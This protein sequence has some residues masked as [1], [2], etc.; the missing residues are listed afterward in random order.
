MQSN[1]SIDPKADPLLSSASAVAPHH[2]NPPNAS[3]VVNQE[4]DLD[5]I[6]TLIGK[7]LPFEACLYHQILPLSIQGSKLRLGMVNLQDAAALD[8]VRRILAFLNYS[9]IPQTI[10]S[11]THHKVLSAYLNLVE[12]RAKKPAHLDPAS[13][14]RLDAGS[15]A[16][17]P[18]P[19]SANPAS[20]KETLVLES[21]D[22]LTDWNIPSLHRNTT[23]QEGK[24][25]LQEDLS[26]ASGATHT[27]IQPLSNPA[28]P[29]LDSNAARTNGSPVNPFSTIDPAALDALDSTAFPRPENGDVSA[30]QLSQ[31][32]LLSNEALLAQP[33]GDRD[34]PRQDLRLPDR[35]S[36]AM[37]VP[38][39]PWPENAL[40][41]LKISPQYLDSSPE[42]LSHLPPQQLIQELLGRIVDNGIGRLYFE[43][44]TPGGRVLWS[45]NGVVQSML[46]N[47]SKELFDGLLFQLKRLMRLPL[48]PIDQPL[49]VEIE[50]LYE[51][52]RILLRLRI[53]P[54]P[55]GEEA[56]LQVLRGAALKFYQQQQLTNLSRDTLTIAKE[57]QHKIT[58]LH[59]RARINLASTDGK[60]NGLDL[61]RLIQSVED[62]LTRLKELKRQ[63][64]E[65]DLS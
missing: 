60:T 58:E 23:T 43:R 11:E 14:N 4:T 12:N 24:T 64:E 18:R 21:P 38:P 2:P 53:I 59:N 61:D 6:F 42:I 17:A 44:Q 46:D 56:T 63:Q 10:T 31:E 51:R 37:A 28:F 41:S 15:Q 33:E 36:E 34:Q 19:A 5:S 20:L 26:A 29:P 48:K 1:G 8:Y 54:K 39:F 45:E 47:L 25:C 55:T 22:L 52:N 3:A 27:E 65:R 32:S 50:R 9:L 62:Q 40:P 7:V 57:L 16:P 49:Q 30:V 35:V 13:L